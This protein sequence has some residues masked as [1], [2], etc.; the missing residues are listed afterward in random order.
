MSGLQEDSAVPVGFSTTQTNPADQAYLPS[1]EICTF[2]L[3]PIHTA[4]A[5]MAARGGHFLQIFSRLTEV[6]WHVFRIAGRA[7]S[8]PTCNIRQ[9]T[10]AQGRRENQDARTGL[11]TG[12]YGRHRDNPGS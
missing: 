7:C 1:R 6:R 10:A 3:S 9:P 11:R 12:P 2:R 8:R 4:R 5:K